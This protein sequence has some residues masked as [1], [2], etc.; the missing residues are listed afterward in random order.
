MQRRDSISPI[1]CLT[2]L[3]IVAELWCRQSILYATRVCLL[4]LAC[5]T[6]FLQHWPSRSWG[7]RQENSYWLGILPSHGRK[8]LEVKPTTRGKNNSPDANVVTQTLWHE[9]CDANTVTQTLWHNRCEKIE[10]NAVTQFQMIFSVVVV[11]HF[12]QSDE[13]RNFVV[14]RRKY[15]TRN[16]WRNFRLEKWSPR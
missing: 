16:F 13:K 5:L 10:K 14:F 8:I 15:R 1:H 12:G 11:W 6:V 4:S 3:K 9:R 2:S 7:G